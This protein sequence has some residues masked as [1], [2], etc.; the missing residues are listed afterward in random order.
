[1]F[2]KKKYGLKDNW[3]KI[4]FLAAILDFGMKKTL[5]CKNNLINGFLMAKLV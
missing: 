4:K 2:I 3:Q 5:N 1:M